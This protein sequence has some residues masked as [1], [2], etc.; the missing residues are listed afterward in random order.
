[1]T[2]RCSAVMHHSD[3]VLFTHQMPLHAARLKRSHPTIIVLSLIMTLND[4]CVS[5]GGG[6]GELAN[7]GN[8]GVMII[9]TA[10]STWQSVIT[11]Y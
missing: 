2:V 9:S 3:C 10:F 5:G 11:H 7:E 4:P 6:G 1:M 8:S